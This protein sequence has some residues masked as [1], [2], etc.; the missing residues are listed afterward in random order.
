MIKSELQIKKK[1]KTKLSFGYIKL[2]EHISALP[3]SLVGN[4]Q[5]PPVSVFHFRWHCCSP[6]TKESNRNTSVELSLV[7]TAHASLLWSQ[8]G[9]ISIPSW[10]LSEPIHTAQEKTSWD[11]NELLGLFQQLS[12]V[13]NGPR[14]S[15][16]LCVLWVTVRSLHK[17]DLSLW[18]CSAHLGN[19]TTSVNHS[20]NEL[21]AAWFRITHFDSPGFLEILA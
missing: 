9:C 12:G 8:S 5:W 21:G 7:L 17:E 11:S 1:I 3:N 18:I 13:P 16:M 20:P 14:D 4:C 15:R 19:V 6:W 10:S 2:S